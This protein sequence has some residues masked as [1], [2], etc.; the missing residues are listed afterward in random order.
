MESYNA[1]MISNKQLRIHKKLNLLIIILLITVVIVVT[2]LTLRSTNH[3]SLQSAKTANAVSLDSVALLGM[4]ELERQTGRLSCYR[5]AWFGNR[6]CETY[7]LRLYRTA[8]D[9]KQFIDTMQQELLVHGWV[10][11]T[12]I[13]SSNFFHLSPKHDVKG[14]EVSV[15]RL[16][17]AYHGKMPMQSIVSML[18]T[19][20]KVPQLGNGTALYYNDALKQKINTALTNGER[21]LLVSSHT[22]YTTPL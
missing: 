1:L 16:G 21:L 5:T 22:T 4:T 2:L 20:N 3:E 10:A 17:P 7:E 18:L 11:D 9:D 19:K 15:R 12:D 8:L 14:M 13:P 6:S